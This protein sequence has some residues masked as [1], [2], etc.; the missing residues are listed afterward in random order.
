AEFV[1][2]QHIVKSGGVIE[3]AI[4]NG[5]LGSCIFYG[6][7]G[8]GKTTL[9]NIIANSG[10]GI[11]KKLNAINSGVA[12]AKEIIAEAKQNL[13]LYGRRTYLLLDECHRWNKAQSDSVLE[14]IENGEII[15]IG[16]TT[17]NPYT[18]MTRAIVSRCRVFEFKPLEK[19]DIKLAVLNAIKSP[20]GLGEFAIYITPDALDYLSFAVGGDVRKALNTL[21]LA[22]TTGRVENGKIVID[23]ELIAECLEQKVMS[24]DESNYYDM[25]SAFCK[26]IRGSDADSALFYAFRMIESGVDPLIIFRRLIAHCSEDIGMANSN[27]LVVATSAMTAYQNMGKPEGLI[28]MT[29]AIIYA[30][31]SDKSNSVIVARDMAEFDARNV[32]IVTIPNALKNHPSTNADGS[33]EYKYPHDYGGYL[34]QQYMPKELEGKVYYTPQ[35]NGDEKGMVRK[36]VFKPNKK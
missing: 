10:N 6:P 17:E 7:P 15:F 35:N 29:H 34:Y 4:K 21:E 18:S 12:D 30:C 2:Q 13:L 22:S 24:L 5:T 25:L 32:K 14:A 8:T 26:S 23:K 33:G 11:F 27:A 1:G 3:K 9:A 28:P 19:D 31:E 20:K 16:S 36:K